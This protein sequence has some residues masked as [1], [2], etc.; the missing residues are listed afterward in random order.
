HSGTDGMSVKIVY[1][2]VAVQV[3]L[4]NRALISAAS[5]VDQPLVCDVQPP[6]VQLASQRIIG[7]E[8]CELAFGMFAR[9]DI[10]NGALDSFRRALDSGQ[11][12]ARLAFGFFRENLTVRHWCVFDGF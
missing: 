11:E 12:A 9:R 5:A 4:S 7:D 1:D 10:L 6:M 3:D 8:T 2:L